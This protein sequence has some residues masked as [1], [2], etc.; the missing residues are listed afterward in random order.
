MVEYYDGWST[1]FRSFNPSALGRR[2]TKNK[3]CGTAGRLWHF[4]IITPFHCAAAVTAPASWYSGGSEEESKGG[5]KKWREQ[6]AVQ[7]QQRAVQQSAVQV[8]F[9]RDRHNG[10]M[11]ALC[12]LEFAPRAFEFQKNVCVSVNKGENNIRNF[13]KST[14]SVN[15]LKCR[16]Q[17]HMRFERYRVLFFGQQGRK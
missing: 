9:I 3:I 8:S 16:K 17:Y 14:M 5:L 15:F 4:I 10:R 12:D 1:T 2:L 6:S 7:L 11:W 13:E